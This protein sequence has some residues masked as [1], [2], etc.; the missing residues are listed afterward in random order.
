MTKGW[1]ETIPGG[2]LV[3]KLNSLDLAEPK[4]NCRTCRVHSG[5][6]REPRPRPFK[7][8]THL[9]FW[10]AYQVGA[11]LTAGNPWKFQDH[12]AF[13]FLPVG[14]APKPSLRALQASISWES[15]GS[16]KD[17]VCPYYQKQRGV[18][19]VF[20]FRPPECRR[21]YCASSHPQGYL[22]RKK[23]AQWNHSI[24]E[25]GLKE[26]LNLFGYTERDWRLWQDYLEPGGE[27]LSPHKAFDE[28]GRAFEFYREVFN[29]WPKA[30]GA[31]LVVPPFSMLLASHRK[32]SHGE[33]YQ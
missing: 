11:F 24:I 28:P 15:R 13:V 19:G 26:T 14:V 4:V 7:C 1:T 22:Y 17:M 9:P 25:Q 2:G 31:E 3:E 8:C 27:A 20:L 32:V 16:H 10:S 30:L 21:Y 18:C 12:E 29:G 5:L 6:K 23:V 33:S